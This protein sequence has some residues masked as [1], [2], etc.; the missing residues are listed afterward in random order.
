MPFSRA[1]LADHTVYSEL[2]PDWIEQMIIR[3]YVQL[4]LA[5]DDVEGRRTVTLIR[6]GAVEVRLTETHH[7]QPTSFP[8]FW[9]E[10]SFETNGGIIDSL[11][12]DEFDEDELSAAVEF[13]REAM[14]WRQTLH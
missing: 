9:L 12:C 8:R 11:G 14:H 2:S 5:S 10:L 1:M 7:D 4:A 6:L 13:V 3:A